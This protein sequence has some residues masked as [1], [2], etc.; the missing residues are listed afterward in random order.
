MKYLNF[1]SHL[2]MDYSNIFYNILGYLGRAII[3]IGSFYFGRHISKTYKGK[4]KN[5]SIV[6]GLIIFLSLV[7]WSSYGS[8]TE[9]ADPL[10]GGGDVVTD[11]EPSDKERNEYGLTMFFV[12]TIPALFGVYKGQNEYEN[13]KNIS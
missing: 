10:R 3:V 4:L 11:F 1:F 8:H 13:F 12:L 5:Y 6:L 2:L 7:M 9:D